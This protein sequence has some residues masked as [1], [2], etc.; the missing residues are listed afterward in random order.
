MPP[1]EAAVLIL[2]TRWG[3]PGLLHFLQATIFMKMGNKAMKH[4]FVL[5]DYK[6]TCRV[7]LKFQ[8]KK[9]FCKEGKINIMIDVH[10]SNKIYSFAHNRHKAICYFLS[11]LS[12]AHTFLVRE[13][14]STLTK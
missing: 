5:V 9:L 4:I 1:M 6:T 7:L 10:D 3:F 14:I 13:I 2:V 12:L 8:W 11:L